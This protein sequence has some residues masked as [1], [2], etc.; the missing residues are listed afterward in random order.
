MCIRDRITASEALNLHP[1]LNIDDL[2]G[3]VF[4]PKDGQTNPIDT[5]RALA[6]GARNRGAQIFENIR[7]QGA[8]KETGKVHGVVTDQGKIKAEFVVN[9]AGLWGRQVGKMAGVNVPLHA[10]E[11]FYI[12]T[13]E[14]G[15]PPSLPVLRD[16]SGWCYICLLYTSPSPRD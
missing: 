8:L 13:E 12:V 11:H 10:S 14:M 6:Q 9:C 15:I 16:P 7:V 3:A 4:L 5:T 1:Y 2:C